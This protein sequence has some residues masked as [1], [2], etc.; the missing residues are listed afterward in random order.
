MLHLKKKMLS[1]LNG[2]NIRN[3]KKNHNVGML[4]KNI[5]EDSNALH[6]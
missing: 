3:L 5:S 2:S 4:N 1:R 6:F